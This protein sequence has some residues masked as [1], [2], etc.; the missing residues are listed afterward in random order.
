MHQDPRYHPL[1]PP[2]KPPPAWRVEPLS[3]VPCRLVSFSG[4]IRK[5]TVNMGRQTCPV[6]CYHGAITCSSI[7]NSKTSSSSFRNRTCFELQLHGQNRI[8]PCTQPRKDQ[9]MRTRQSLDVHRYTT[10]DKAP[11]ISEPHVDKTR[12]VSITTNTQHF[13]EVQPID[14]AY[15]DASPELSVM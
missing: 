2:M 14:S 13:W 3:C 15:R 10:I 7:S 1:R 5:T 12:G 11:V 9:I 8:S 6:M 4:I